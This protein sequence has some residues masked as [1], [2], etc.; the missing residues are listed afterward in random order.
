MQSDLGV[1]REIFKLTRKEELW[2]EDDFPVML[3][4]E[5]ELVTS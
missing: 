3:S 1:K 4:G 5:L 2:A